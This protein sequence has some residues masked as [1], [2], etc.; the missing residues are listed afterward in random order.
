VFAVALL[1]DPVRHRVRGPVHHAEVIAERI[2][3]RPYGTLL[4][5]LA[6]TIIEGGAD[7]DHIMLGDKPGSPHWRADTVSPS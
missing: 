6:V 1:F 3:A 2:S 7:R 5:T 4:L